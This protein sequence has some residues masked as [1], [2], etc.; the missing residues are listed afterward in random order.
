MWQ[1]T[2]VAH[3]KLWVWQGKNKEKKKPSLWWLDV[4]KIMYITS[5]NQ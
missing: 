1:R 3:T 4:N 2:Y 5:K